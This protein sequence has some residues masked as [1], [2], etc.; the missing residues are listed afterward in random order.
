MSAPRCNVRQ[1]LVAQGDALPKGQGL[2]Q[3]WRLRLGRA[4]LW[5]VLTLVSAL[6]VAT[7]A[8]MRRQATPPAL[9]MAFSLPTSYDRL[10][11][12]AAQPRLMSSSGLFDSCTSECA[13]LRCSRNCLAC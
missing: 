1:G 11:S 13:A 10:Q 12:A 5:S 2:W 4:C 6:S 7:R 9:T 3:V 8:M